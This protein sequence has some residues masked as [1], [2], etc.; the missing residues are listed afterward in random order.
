M[1]VKHSTRAADEELRR[2]LTS[3][4]GRRLLAR[5]PAAGPEAAS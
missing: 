5:V 1:T 3:E 2:V 4:V